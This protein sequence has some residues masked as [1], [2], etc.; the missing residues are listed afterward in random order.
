MRI[1]LG[2]GHPADVHFFK[3]FINDLKNKGNGVY[4]AAREKEIT[5][6]L[7]DKLNIKYH[8]ISFHQ[9]TIIKKLIDY[10]IR[11]ERTYRLCKKLKP[12]ITIGVG[13]FYLP[14]IGKLQGFPSIVITDTEHVK[15][16]SFLTFP[17]ASH[18]MTPSCFKKDLGKNHIKGNLG[19]V[20]KYL[21]NFARAV[22]SGSHPS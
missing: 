21:N 3:Y 16:D 6:Y 11:W 22:G 14:Q 4:V 7:L 13:D 17:F 19:D 20:L 2:I 5:Y 9:K 10:F 18:I 12:D 15:Y 1:L 8:R